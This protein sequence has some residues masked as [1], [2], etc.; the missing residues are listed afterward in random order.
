MLVTLAVFEVW[1]QQLHLFLK[2]PKLIAVLNWLDWLPGSLLSTVELKIP[3]SW[4]IFWSSSPRALKCHSMARLLLKRSFHCS[5]PNSSLPPSLLFWTPA[6]IRGQPQKYTFSPLETF[7]K[8]FH[9]I[10]WKK[11]FWCR[12]QTEMAQ[13]SFI[14]MISVLKSLNNY[15]DHWKTHC[16]KSWSKGALLSLENA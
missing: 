15:I 8:F 12:L 13:I 4:Q 7:V 3:F 14:F 2:P 6:L 9:H 11:L 10:W 1:M 5:P 16:A